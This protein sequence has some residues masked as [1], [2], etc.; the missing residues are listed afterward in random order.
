MLATL[1]HPNHIVC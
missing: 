1:V